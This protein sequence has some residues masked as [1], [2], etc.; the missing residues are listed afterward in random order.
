V[1]D[2]NACT[3]LV[4]DTITFTGSSNFAINCAGKGTKPLGAAQVKLVE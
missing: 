1:N 3:Q 4:A 2:S